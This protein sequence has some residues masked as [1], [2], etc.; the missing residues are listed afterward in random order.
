M[1]PRWLELTVAIRDEVERSFA[2]EALVDAG[3]RGVEEIPEGLRT[4]FPEPPDP[5]P[6]VSL[7]RAS[8][9]ALRGGEEPAVSWRW[10]LHED[11]E[12]LWRQGLGPRRVGTRIVVQPS[13]TEYTARAGDVVLTIDPGIAFGTAEHATTR[14]ALE[15]LESRVEPGQT[16]ADVGTGTGILAIAAVRLGARRA[17]GFDTDP[18]AWAVT[19]EN[20]SRNGVGHR[21]DVVEGPMP[22]GSPEF[23]GLVANIEWVR[24]RPLVPT[25]ARRVRVGGWMVLSGVLQE[26]RDEA[27]HTLGDLALEAVMEVAEEEWWAVALVAAGD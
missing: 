10:Q 3:A 27:R 9:A 13:W 4:Y 11:W 12:T 22:E 14:L 25:L 5:E 17:V 24:L 6:F 20:A 23:D 18:Y 19:R 26:Q 21:V 15:L 1:P 8:L 7:L 16:V 2:A